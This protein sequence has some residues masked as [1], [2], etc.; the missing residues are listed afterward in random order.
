[1]SW[2]RYAIA[3]VLMA[4]L[5]HLI[6]GFLK[7]NHFNPE[8]YLA[9][10]GNYEV[11]IKRDVWG[12][13][14]IEGRRDRDTAFGFAYAQAE[15]HYQVIEDAM[16]FYR[17]IQSET[18]GYDS[19]PLDYLIQL[20]EI[21]PLVEEQYEHALSQE[22][23]DIL[24][25]FADGLN[26]WAALNPGRVDQSLFP[27]TARD[28][29]ASHSLQ[30]LLFYGIQRPIMELFEEERKHHISSDSVE[31]AWQLVEGAPLPRGSNAIAVSPLGSSD[32]STR[33]LINSHQ[34]L[35]GPVAWYEAHLKSD[36]GWHVMGGV[37]P[38]SPFI[39]VGANKHVAWGATVNQ[40][41]LVDVY[42]LEINPENQ[43]QYRLD[44]RWVDLEVKQARIKVKIIGNFYWTIS[45]DMYYSRH[46]PVIRRDHGSYALRYAGRGEVRQ[47]EQ[48]FAMNKSDS[49]DAWRKAM[50]QLA[51]SS[52]N[53]VAADK[54][55]NIGF[56]H[57]SQSPVR[58]EGLDWRGY[59]PGDR[60]DL[61]WRDYLP[62]AELPQV[63]NPSS[64]YL[65]STNQSPFFVTAPED[66]LDRANFSE[67]FGFPRRMTNRATRGL[68]LF[69]G[70]DKVSEQDF[71]NIKFDNRYSR[72][73]R[74][75][76]YLYKL[77]EVDYPDDSPYRDAL[78]FLK[79]WDLATNV[80]NTTAALGVCTISEEWRAEQARREPPSVQA[81]FE[82]CVDI[83]LQKFERLD[84]PW[85][86]VNRIVRGDKNFAL[87]GGPDV[88]R[89]V[90]GTGLEEKGYL[91]ASGG[92]GLFIFVSWDKE[93]NQKIESI[94]QFGSATL[95][96]TSAHYADQLPLFVAER[97]KQTYFD[98]DSLS[99][100]TGRVYEP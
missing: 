100:N 94:H 70:L 46:G 21:W 14:H 10:R 38:G 89:A 59:L 62:F 66:N 76:R 20:L 26:Y 15:D 91:T 34:P 75:I 58:K 9:R 53:F 47:V 79:D 49:L 68:E 11:V 88:L 77:F 32:G 69:A 95:D 7:P 40:P 45:Q 28:I 64:G 74:A 27:L 60:S 1:M 61:I 37:F 87:N 71:R 31:T 78:L 17:G 81:E 13:P 55:G 18:N 2:V 57:N 39:N 41:D 29:V 12:V 82:K 54:D 50:D 35:T 92:D 93:G 43:N 4:F 98:A 48:W 16:R 86:D 19:I 65:L 33:L 5:A 30:H 25:G 36:Q 99:N 42:V 24:T 97:M 84:V 56:F 52:F 44:G 96:T 83:L 73:S 67:V 51:I 72:D 8:S 80:E 85:G 23:K 3:V 63:V 22:M 90:Y 6:L